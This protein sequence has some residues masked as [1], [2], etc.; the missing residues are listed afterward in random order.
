MLT[1]GQ[2]SNLGNNTRIMSKHGRQVLRVQPYSP[3][4]LGVKPYLS[5]HFTYVSW[6]YNGPWPTSSNSRKPSPSGWE[7]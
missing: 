5:T 7:G 1:R 4:S 6:V 3:S 2:S